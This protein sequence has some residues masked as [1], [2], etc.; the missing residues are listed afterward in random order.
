[1]LRFLLL[2]AG[3]VLVGLVLVDL[4]WTTLSAAGGAGPVT[5]RTS[6]LA[7]RLVKGRPRKAEGRRASG[8]TVV[9]AV[10][11]SWIALLWAGWALAF[12]ASD[13]AVVASTGG[14]AA[15]VVARAYF[16]GYTVFTLGNGDFKPGGPVWQIATVAATGSG[17]VLIT[18]AI[19]YLVP[20]TGAATTRRSL[21]G[22]IASLGPT[23]E[24][25]V[26][27]SWNGRDFHGLVGHLETLAVQ[28]HEAGQR[29]LTYPVLHF[30]GSSDRRTAAPVA[31]AVLHEALTLLRWGV[32]AGARPPEIALEPARAAVGSFLDTLAGA[33]IKPAPQ[34]LPPPDLARLRAWGIPTVDDGAFHAA[35]DGERRTRCLVAGLISGAGWTP[36]ASFLA[37][38]TGSADS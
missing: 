37:P 16:V 22:Y 36:P 13:Q 35:L 3:L 2:P 26:A 23:P 38:G 27:R 33:F 1:M 32:A 9:V 4:L 21:A 12:S 24:Q 5:A 25:I 28:I 6:T 19:T 34:P 10:L 14:Q 17:L 18:L 29:H 20:V 30:F 11:V 7:W 8:V 31:I 15:S